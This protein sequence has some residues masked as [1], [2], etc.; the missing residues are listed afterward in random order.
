MTTAQS[1]PLIALAFIDR[2]PLFFNLYDQ[3]GMIAAR[4]M[5]PNRWLKE[6]KA[7][8][9]WR[10]HQNRQGELA[11]LDRLVPASRQKS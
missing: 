1:P 9:Y 5:L 4:G 7:W 10:Y 8:R 6:L 2:V 3:E 11:F